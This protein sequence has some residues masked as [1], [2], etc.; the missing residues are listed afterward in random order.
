[1]RAAAAVAQGRLVPNKEG[2]VDLPVNMQSASVNQ[3][4]YVKREAD[5]TAWV[6]LPETTDANFKGQLYCSK[7]PAEAPTKVQ[8]IGPKAGGG[9][10]P[11]QVTVDGT[12][13]EGW[14]S[15]HAGG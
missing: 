10:G 2:V 7:P 12:A 13:P 14:Y 9:A 15:V 4:A 1:M 8:I 3:K 11:V 6:F 5:G